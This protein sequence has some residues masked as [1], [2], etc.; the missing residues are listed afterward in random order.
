MS[1]AAVRERVRKQGWAAPGG[2]HDFLVR[3]LKL[4]LPLVIGMLLAFLAVAPLRK[5]QEIS[6]LLDKNKVEVAKERM[7]VQSASYRGQDNLGRPFT[8]NADSAVQATSRDPIVD[9]LG[10]AARIR[11]ESGPATLRAKRARYNMENETVNVVGPIVFTGADGYRLQTR[12]VAVDLNSRSMRS[13]GRV[14]GRMPLGR[15]SADRMA[16]SLPDQ[17]VVLTGRA[18]LHIVQGGIRS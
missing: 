15:F 16:A 18:R 13:R 2:V 6:F 7:R 10:M 9:V 17:R 14:D 8:I 4:A 1:E 3:F 12:D 11:L 5:G